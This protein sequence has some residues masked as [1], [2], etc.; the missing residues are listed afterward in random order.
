MSKGRHSKTLQKAHGSKQEQA[1]TVITC[2]SG[3]GVI[4][5][6]STFNV[7]QNR[8]KKSVEKKNLIW[9]TVCGLIS[10]LTLSFIGSPLP[11]G[12]HGIAPL[13]SN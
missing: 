5:Q 2:G 11:I 9:K 7:E 6:K 8:G 13:K 4:K 3:H 12:F 10:S 1:E